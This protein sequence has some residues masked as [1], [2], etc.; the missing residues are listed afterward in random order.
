M[1]YNVTPCGGL[2]INTGSLKMIG[3]VVTDESATAVANYFN[4]SCGGQYFDSV[5]FKTVGKTITA[6]GATSVENSFVANCSLPFD[7]AKFELDVDGA[8]KYK[9]ALLTITT[10]PTDA[11]V[12]VTD[13]NGN[14]VNPN[15]QGKYPVMVT[16]EYTYTVTKTGYVAQTASVVISNDLTIDVVLTE[17][18]ENP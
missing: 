18:P 9:S 6:N 2:K 12:L 10:T 11:V 4:A 3:N 14:V 8:I 13:W 7:A 15:A 5:Y 1:A 17:N 16:K